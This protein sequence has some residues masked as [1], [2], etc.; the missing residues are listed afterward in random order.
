MECVRSGMKSFHNI[1]ENF[2]EEKEQH[3]NATF[4]GK[5]NNVVE[6]YSRGRQVQHLKRTCLCL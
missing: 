4:C 1:L 5:A 2:K 6:I 3:M